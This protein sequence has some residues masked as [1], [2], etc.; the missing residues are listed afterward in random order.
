MTVTITLN[1]AIDYHIGL[2]KNI[3]GDSLS[4]LE[5]SFYAGGKGINVSRVLHNLDSPTLAVAMLGGF[6]GEFIIS[7]TK[8]IIKPI[9]IADNNR[10]N[11]KIKDKDSETEIHGVAPEISSQEFQNLCSQI[12]NI[13][14][15][16]ILVLSGSIPKSL[17]NS[18][19]KAIAQLCSQKT[20]IVLDTRGEALK[21]CL[22][23][24]SIFLLKPNH[25]EIAELFSCTIDSSEQA[26]VLAQKL[27]NTYPIEHLILSLGAKGAYF[28]YKDEIYF[29]SALEGKLISSVGAGDSVVAG[30]IAH[31]QQTQDSLEAFKYG[32][33]CGAGTAFSHGLCTISMATSLYSK[34]QCLRIK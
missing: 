31:Y 33:A 18:A 1:P 7:Q 3:K 11:V 20:K 2:E 9:F 13:K 32:I 34:V 15:I 21:E 24:E 30:F 29:S 16:D 23:L 8:D 4:A 5:N 10:I 26:L 19:Y 12:R 25:H 14:D 27:K 22:S 6:S 17:G 28:L